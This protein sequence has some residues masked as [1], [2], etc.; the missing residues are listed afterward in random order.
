MPCDGEEAAIE[1][2]RLLGRLL[3]G[4]G[5]LQAAG[6]AERPGGGQRDHEGGAE[7]A[8]QEGQ[9][10]QNLISTHLI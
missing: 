1:E 8:A 2:G 6:L 5:V 4:E 7:R 9:R 3:Q 10:D